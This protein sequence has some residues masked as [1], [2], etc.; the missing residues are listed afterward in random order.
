[1]L[2]A[3]L[4]AFLCLVSQPVFAHL[5]SGI[6]VTQGTPAA[7]QL[8]QQG[9]EYYEKAQFASAVKVWQQAT[10]AYQVQGDRP[11]PSNGL[12]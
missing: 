9:R 4:T 2:I 11:A 10:Q 7:S 1:V 12:E 3:C 8:L 6:S 5:S